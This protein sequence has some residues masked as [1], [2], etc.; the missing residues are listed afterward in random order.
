M[1]VLLLY[2]LLFWTLKFLQLSK[3]LHKEI[4]KVIMSLEKEINEDK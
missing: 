3:R 1:P 2:T 4:V